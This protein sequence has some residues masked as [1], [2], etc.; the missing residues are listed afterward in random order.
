M[1]IA[2]PDLKVNVSE[3][4]QLTNLGYRLELCQVALL[5]GGVPGQMGQLMTYAVNDDRVKNTKPSLAAVTFVW[6]HRL[7]A[8]LCLAS[9]V[10]Y[11]VALIGLNEGSLSRFDL[12]PI[13]WQVA[14]SSL[15]VLLPVAAVGLW[16]VVSWG[17]VIWVAAAAGEL[18][19]YAGFPQLFGAKPLIIM[20]H[21]SVAS[22][23]LI[24]RFVLH[25]QAKAAAR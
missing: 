25:R 8:L 5:I 4:L 18:V 13:H 17:P 9:G 23:Y 11:W 15:A 12:M 19:M 22:L 10:Y 2:Q 6:F 16:M 14:A 24:F 1:P 7:I 21:L 3:Q 20:S